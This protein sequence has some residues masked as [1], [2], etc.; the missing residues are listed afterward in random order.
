MTN[1]NPQWTIDISMPLNGLTDAQRDELFAKVAN[2]VYE[3]MPEERDWDPFMG[4]TVHRVG[5]PTD[6]PEETEKV[7]HDAADLIE[8]KAADAAAGTWYVKHHGRPDERL[9]NVP[10]MLAGLSTVHSLSDEYGGRTLGGFKPQHQGAENAIWVALMAPDIAPFL[11]ASLRQA[12]QSAREHGD[13]HVNWGLIQ[14]AEAVTAGL[15]EHTL[16]GTTPEPENVV[17]EEPKTREQ[18]IAEE[19]ASATLAFD[20]VE[21]VVRT[22]G[23][24]QDKRGPYVGKHSADDHNWPEDTGAA[25]DEFLAESE[26][27]ER[28][29]EPEPKQD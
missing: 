14:F 8:Q 26:K 23:H 18:I 9:T 10:D 11:V 4:A 28:A 5:I 16:F 22:A 2:F 6:G 1:E 7:L 25:L 19:D 29:P 13:R 12:A 21:P 17:I 3:S 15:D 20:G 24:F 27:N